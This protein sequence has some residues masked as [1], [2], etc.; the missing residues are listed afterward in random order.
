MSAKVLV[1]DDSAFARKII[2]DILS[3]E[4]YEIAGEAED[5][6]EAVK[7]YEKTKP[8]LVT[9]D[10]IMPEVDNMDGIDAVREILRMDPKARILMV[11][12]VGQREALKEAEQAGAKGFIVKPFDSSIII[13]EVRKI[14]EKKPETSN[15]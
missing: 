10:I 3:K 5:G 15:Q 6:S 1:V 11:T 4:G 13:D 2:I 14:L 9:M 8:D 7:L 12:A